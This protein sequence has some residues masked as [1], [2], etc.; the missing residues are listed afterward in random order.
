MVNNGKP[1]REI[2][3]DIPSAPAVD[4]PDKAD[5]YIGDSPLWSLA[6]I[7]EIA[8]RDTPTNVTI[9]MV[10]T[11]SEKDYENLL[12]N[13]FSLLEVLSLVPKKGKFK[14][15]WWCKTS[16]AKGRDGRPRGNGAW[17]PCDAY[18]VTV[19]YEHPLTRYS[20]QANYYLKACKNHSG[21]VLLFVS[22]HV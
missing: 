9:R 20:G 21:D 5:R 19:S 1:Y 11:K 12:D 7:I 8:S 4:D 16:P 17:V 10:T 13:G 22:L 15:A 18:S 14:G 6:E 3:P 2:F